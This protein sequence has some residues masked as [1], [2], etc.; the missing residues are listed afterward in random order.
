MAE[1]PARGAKPARLPNRCTEAESLENMTA[2]L[3]RI[4]DNLD[5]LKPAAEVVHDLAD[6]LDKLCRF[7]KT[8][9]PWLLA[10]IPFVL[11]AV[12]AVTPEV[13]A[14]LKAVIAAMG[15]NPGTG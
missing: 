5:E 14:G 6:R 15:I 8:R 4:A 10:S 2:A 13:A 7:L 3:T 12:G 11:S 9:G 1:T